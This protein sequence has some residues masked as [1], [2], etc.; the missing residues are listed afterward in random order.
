MTALACLHT[1]NVHY[2]GLGYNRYSVNTD[3]FL[4]P[5]ESL[6]ISMSDDIV[7]TD[8]ASRDFHFLQT[9]FLVP[10]LWTRWI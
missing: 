7:R 5:A 4:V 9:S 6:L 1:V 10:T 2:N 3:F 8:S